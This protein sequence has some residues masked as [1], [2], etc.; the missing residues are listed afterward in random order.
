[1]ISGSW[2]R[3]APEDSSTPLQTMSY[4]QARM[5]SGSC[6]SSASRPPCGMENGL[7]ENSILPGL[8]VL[9]EHREVDDPAEPEDALLEV[10]GALG[11]LDADRAHDLRDLVELARAE[12]DRGAGLGAQA[13]GR[14]ARDVVLG[15]ELGDRAGQRAVLADPDPG[16]A[17]GALLDGELAE[18]VEELARLV[19]GVRHGQ[20][21]YVLA[22]E[23]L[24]APSP[25]RRRRRRRAP[26]GR[27]GPACR[28]RTSASP[29]GTGCA[30]TAR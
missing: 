26:A 15:E 12:E 3:M 2:F 21:A 29:R 8:L 22:G 1:M 17:L 16:Q 13:L 18:L 5:S 23:R 20:G 19:G 30:G 7:C 6:V 28:S 24:E 4:C 11:G 10:P 9:L 27:A 14:A 25:R